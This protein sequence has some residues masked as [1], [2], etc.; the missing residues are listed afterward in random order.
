MTPTLL[1][2]AGIVIAG[3]GFGA[4]WGLRPVPDPSAALAEQTAAIEAQGE[5]I[6]SVAAVVSRPVVIDAQIRE[7]LASIPPACGA[8][9]DPSSLACMVGQCWQYG[10]SAAQRPEC[11]AIVDEYLRQKAAGCV[12]PRPPVE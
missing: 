5:A 8:A 7:A 4:G 10:Q 1:A 3:A 6:E 11:R 2:I 12:E 9:G